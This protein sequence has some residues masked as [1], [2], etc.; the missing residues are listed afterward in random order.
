MIGTLAAAGAA[1]ALVDSRLRALVWCAL[2]L[3]VLALVRE[4]GRFLPV[5]ALCL[6]VPVFTG[7]STGADS[8][9][10]FAYTSSLLGDQDL[11]FGNQ[12]SR[13]GF[14]SSARTPT[15]LH[16]NPMAIGPG[17]LWIPAVAAVHFWLLITGGARDALALAPPYFAAAA[18]TSIALAL[19]GVFVL[20]RELSRLFGASAGRIAVV[21]V[22]LCSPVLYYVTLQPLMSHASA[23]GGACLVVALTLRAERLATPASWMAV[24]AALGLV[25]LMRPQAVPLALV[26]GAGLLR[27]R[28][29]IRHAGLA[30]AAALVTFVPQLVAWKIL[31]G[32]FLTIPQGAGFIDWSGDHAFDVLFSADRGLFNWHPAL[33]L[34][35]AGL[36]LALRPFASIAL[37]SLAALAFTTFIN[38]SVSDWNASAAF[39]AR[40]FDVMLPLLAFGLAVLLS[41]ARPI[42]AARPLFLPAVLFGAAALWNVS[43]ID[44]SRGTAGIALP[45]D[46]VAR[47][48]AGQARRFADRTVGLLGPAARAAVYRVFVGLFAYEN[49]RPGGDFDLAT[50]ES[51]FLGRGWSETQ[52]WD[53]GTMFRYLLFPKACITIPIDEPFDL[54]GVITARAPARIQDQRITVM[55]NDRA[56]TTV[57]L[58][59]QWTDLNFAAPARFW[60]SGENGLCLVAASK[61]PGDEGDDRSFAA[62]VVRVQFP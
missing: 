34:G 12:W 20:G 17:L 31:Y 2:A 24:G 50:L 18:A 15:G 4:R 22:L 42:L 32:S 9:N 30:L 41:W 33:L 59:P 13:L 51:R 16:P 29:G 62:A 61:R 26:A 11:D 54:R 39:G 7:F 49:Y 1:L 36:V 52:A 48:Q 25:M 8:L 57:P 43:L 46:E 58:P 35:L 55:V 27:S 5:L 10:Y 3:A 38:G 23:F 56:V 19:A 45:I 6:S 53:D 14:V 28:A 44:L 40:R 37:A 21:T 47:L 60:R